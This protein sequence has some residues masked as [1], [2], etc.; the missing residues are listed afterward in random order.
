MVARAPPLGPVGRAFVLNNSKCFSLS[1]SLSL[2]WPLPLLL[3]F[4]VLWL[5]GVEREEKRRRGARRV[6]SIRV[7]D[8]GGLDRRSVRCPFF[9]ER[10]SCARASASASAVAQRRPHAPHTRLASRLSLSSWWLVGWLHTTRGS[11][12]SRRGYHD[13]V[14][15]L[16][17]WRWREGS[18]TKGRARGRRTGRRRPPPAHSLSLSSSSSSLPAPT[19]SEKGKAKK[20]P[21]AYYY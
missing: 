1:L 5:R 20:I 13:Q 9:K 16:W 2:L 10:N 11:A 12:S 17:G 7:R 3:C 14:V 21:A 18:K 6:G 8:C 15:R 4:V 19:P